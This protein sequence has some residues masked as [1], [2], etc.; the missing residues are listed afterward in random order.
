VDRRVGARAA[1]L[2]RRLARPAPLLA[3]ALAARVAPAQRAEPARELHAEFLLGSAWSLPTPLVVRLPG[4]PPARLRARYTTRPWDDAP[5]YEYRAGG[6]RARACGDPPAGGDAGLLHHKLYLENPAPPVERFEVTHGY[7]L[8]GAA[9]VRPAGRLGIRLGLAVVVAH[10]EGRIAG[11]RVGGTRRTLLGGGYHVAGLAAQVGAAA[12]TR[13][14]AAAPSSPTPSRRRSSSRRSRACR[15]ATGA[16]RPWCRTSRC[17]R[18][19][20]SA[21]AG[22]GA[23]GR[24]R[25]RGPAHEEAPGWGRWGRAVPCA[26]NAARGRPRPSHPGVPDAHPGRCRMSD[27]LHDLVVSALGR[28]YAVECEIG[29]GGMS[30]VYRARDLRLNRTVAVKVLP[31]ELAYDPAIR[32]RFTREA[33]TSAQL[34]HAHIV[35][36]F[37]VGERDGS[38]TS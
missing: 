13:W 9:L 12:A 10:A 2:A 5:Y 14:R 32:T 4:A 31:P 19:P 18:W 8:A 21:P 22:S 15:W 30:V 20:G 25:A 24:A 3:T 35:P 29:R 17:T 11:E 33:Q 27:A 7:N 28:D 38:R 6:G 1:A 34:S 23:E 16:A 37:D 36:I 26:R